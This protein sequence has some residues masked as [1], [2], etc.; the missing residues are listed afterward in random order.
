M[1]K[2]F[3]LNGVAIRSTY[4]RLKT[5]LEPLTADEPT[6]GLVRYGS[7]TTHSSTLTL[8]HRRL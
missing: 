4:R 7:G 3:A 2:Q 1:W 8:A 5:V 6:I